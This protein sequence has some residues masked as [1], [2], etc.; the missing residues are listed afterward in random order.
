MS[1]LSIFKKRVYQPMGASGRCSS[2]RH[3]SVFHLYH[4]YIVVIMEVKRL[5]YRKMLKVPKMLMTPRRTD[6]P[7]HKNL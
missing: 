3:L 5:I 1:I 2:M 6:A 4:P 7:T